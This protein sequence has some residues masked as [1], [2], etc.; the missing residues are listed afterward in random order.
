LFCKQ[1]KDE[2]SSQLSGI[3]E[4]LTTEAPDF[5]TWCPTFI[6]SD[7]SMFAPKINQ[8]ASI[9]AFWET[10]ELCS[11]LE[12]AYKELKKDYDEN[13][14]KMKEEMIIPID[15]NQK[16]IL[17]QNIVK[18]MNILPFELFIEKQ[19]TNFR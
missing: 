7:I 10:E 11:T 19:H 9:T 14:K 18:L 16:D 13:Q 4:L 15:G 2:F 6:N 5:Q 17:K 1:M 3:D 12:M 8:M